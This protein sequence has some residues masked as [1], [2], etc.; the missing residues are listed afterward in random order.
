MPA[1]K[2]EWMASGGKRIVLISIGIGMAAAMF[3]AN[4]SILKNVS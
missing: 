3:A 4:N 1:S 2:R